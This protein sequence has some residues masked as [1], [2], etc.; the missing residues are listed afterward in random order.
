MRFWAVALIF[1]AMQ[2]PSNNCAVHVEA[3]QYPQ[4]ARLAR[5][6]GEVLVEATVADDGR[7]MA[8][9]ARSGHGILADAAEQNLRKW[10][11]SQGTSRN[12][13]VI[14]VF[15]LEKPEL[16]YSPPSRVVFDLPNKVSVTSNLPAPPLRPSSSRPLAPE[17]R[18]GWPGGPH[19]L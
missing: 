11:F 1:C 9:R 7:V 8:A 4:M 5:I 13:E 14:F 18:L 16:E 10:V 15:R 17:A 3:M 19:L 12:L 6:Q 2:A